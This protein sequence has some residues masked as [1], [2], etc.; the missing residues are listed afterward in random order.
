MRNF[1]LLVGLGFLM[2]CGGTGGGANAGGKNL[3]EK[4][5]ILTGKDWRMAVE[6]IR[7]MKDSLKLEG[8]ENEIFDNSLKNLQFASISFFPDSNLTVSL[9]NGK[10]NIGGRWMFD[11]SGAKLFLSF[12]IA[13]PIAHPVEY[14]SEDSIV[15]GVDR[16]A[17]ILFPKILVPVSENMGLEVND[18]APANDTTAVSGQ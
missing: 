7:P 10:E 5:S 2:A 17:G 14:M 8:R 18:A 16:E 15:L 4:K 13:Q 12:T 11:D 9:S 1:L 3:E 6:A